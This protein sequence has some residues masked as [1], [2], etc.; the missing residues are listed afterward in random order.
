MSSSFVFVLP[1][2]YLLGLGCY[3]FC[4]RAVQSLSKYERL[5]IFDISLSWPVS[6]GTQLI[7]PNV[8]KTVILLTCR[9]AVCEFLLIIGSLSNDDDDGNE[10]VISKYNF[11]FL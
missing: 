10:N 3:S 1:K 2:G 7:K 6:L 8:Y 4:R 5:H 11:S 9:V